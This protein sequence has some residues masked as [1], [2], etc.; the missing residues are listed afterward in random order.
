MTYQKIFNQVIREIQHGAIQKHG[1]K[2]LNNTLKGLDFIIK[3]KIKEI[4]FTYF[5]SLACMSRNN[6]R[7]KTAF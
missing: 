2:I 3:T 5:C 6:R 1:C 4:T 7:I